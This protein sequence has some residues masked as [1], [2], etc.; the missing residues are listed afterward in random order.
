MPAFFRHD[1]GFGTSDDVAGL[2]AYL[3]SDAAAGVTGQ[4]IGVGG[5][6]IQV[7]SHPEP[8]LSAYRDGGWTYDALAADFGAEFGGQLQ[9]VGEKFPPLPEDLQRPAPHRLTLRQ[10]SG[11]Q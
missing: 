10:R 6:R 7:W 3:A 11:P 9:S 2:I 8:V 1:L 4:A 5:D